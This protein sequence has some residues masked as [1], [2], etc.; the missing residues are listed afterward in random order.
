MSEYQY[1]LIGKLLL[2]IGMI[3]LLF[4]ISVPYSWIVWSG[5]PPAIPNP[6]TPLIIA[7]FLLLGFIIAFIGATIQTRFREKNLFLTKFGETIHSGNIW[8]KKSEWGLF[9]TSCE[10][11][12]SINQESKE[13]AHVGYRI[14]KA[15]RA[16]CSDCIRREVKAILD[17]VT[18]RRSY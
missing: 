8:K 2:F 13:T 1:R 14:I 17:R 12:V 9:L 7:A 16:T 6:S 10:R 4:P 11:V 15:N 3:I 5:F 18:H